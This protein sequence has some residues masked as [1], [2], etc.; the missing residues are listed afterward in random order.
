ME[1]GSQEGMNGRDILL[2]IAA[3][4]VLTAL[5]GG[6][7]AHANYVSS[8]PLAGAILPQAP[9][10]V[11]VT[12]SE[13]IQPGSES[14]RVTNTSGAEVQSGGAQVSA[15]D[16]NSMSILLHPIGPGVY[17]VTW[18]AISAADGHFTTG[19]F[20][21]AVENPD[22]SLPGPLP[23]SGA[24]SGAASP[25]AAEVV[26]RYVD[27]F[28]LVVA[29][30][31]AFFG[32]LVWV[33]AGME[34]GDAEGETHAQGLR[35][36]LRWDAIAYF[37]FL[38]AAVAWLVDAWSTIRPGSLADVLDS[39][40]LTSLLAQASLA[41]LSFAAVIILYRAL[42]RADAS[43]GRNPFLVPAILGIVIIAAVS[44]GT[45]GAASAPFS[46]A[47][48]LLEA[49]HLLG[50]VA[51]VGGLF[52][53]VMVRRSVFNESAR[54]LGR[55][56][57]RRFSRLA[58][59]SVAVILGAGIL[60]GVLLVGSWS[61]LLG[62]G[63]GWV[64]IAKMALFAP[65]VALGAHN[66]S[67]LRA[68]STK[69]HELSPALRRLAQNIK[70]EA[71]IGAV[72][73]VLAAV[74]TSLSPPVVV[75]AGSPTFLLHATSQGVRFEFQVYPYP[76]TPGVYTLEAYAWNATDGSAYDGVR[77]GTLT[78]TLTN[79]T[80]PP[81]NVPLE[82]PHGNHL[83]VVSPAMSRPGTWRID[84]HVSRYTGFDVTVTFYIVLH[85]G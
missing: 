53:I 52:A 70:T 51:W 57:L 5:A 6:A 7:S 55:R 43:S 33:P 75:S 62:T 79:S 24:T 37:A 20:S 15:T 28:G 34:L 14:I 67:K 18:N 64:V 17:T 27:L 12:L 39:S 3:L 10:N 41:G 48:L 47:G 23:S 13:A 30:G 71:V 22:G 59:Y 8:D 74:L 78:F 29:L 21:F 42:A 68:E 16:P 65:M 2:P 69:E 61:A 11:T 19:S 54:S 36:L 84:L 58:G 32:L 40:F 49:L 44:L 9:Q 25:A 73:L 76:Q 31:T 77:N 85:A 81:E 26:F 63:Y 50:V 56:S 35:T 46:P 80:L 66:R 38:I 4:L 82:G 1:E 72:V 83:F 60:L 45:H